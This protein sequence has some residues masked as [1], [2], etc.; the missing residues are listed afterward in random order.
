MS[1]YMI[2]DVTVK[3]A[4][5][6]SS[7]LKLAQP[8]LSAFEG[9]FHVQAG[10]VH[11]FEGTWNPKVVIVVEF[12]SLENAHSWYHSKEYKAA[13]AIKPTAMDR[14]MIVVQGI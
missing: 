2:C 5:A 1:V 13:L 11:V 12:P 4:E 6:L 3:D 7:Y 14:N 9:K 10:D 8:T